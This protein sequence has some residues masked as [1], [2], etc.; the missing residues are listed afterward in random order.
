MVKGAQW[1]TI[2]LQKELIKGSYVPEPVIRKLRQYNRR[3]FYLNR[4]KQGSEVCIDSTFQPCSIRLSNYVSDIGS[5]SM[6][7]V[8]I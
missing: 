1:I 4:S 8:M 5:K 2:V 7:K 6:R 3:I